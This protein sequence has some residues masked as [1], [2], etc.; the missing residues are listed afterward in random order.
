MTVAQFGPMSVIRPT[1][2][3]YSVTTTM[4]VS[5][6]ERVPLPMVNVLFQLEESHET[7]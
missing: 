3:P 5:S 7:M 6:P 4:P 2:W 1:T